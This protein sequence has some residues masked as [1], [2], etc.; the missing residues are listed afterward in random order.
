MTAGK[1]NRLYAAKTAKIISIFSFSISAL[2]LFA[3]LISDFSVRNLL[4]S[5]IPIAVGLLIW[6][7]FLLRIPFANALLKKQ[8]SSLNIKFDDSN[9]KPLYPSAMIFLS[10]EWFIAAG[11]LYL[12]KD[13]IHYVTVKSGKTAMGIEYYCVFKCDDGKRKLHMDSKANANK[14]KLWF[15][16]IGKLSKHELAKYAAPILKAKG[17]LKK[18]MRWTKTIGDF[19]VAF[20]IQSSNYNKDDYYIR[21]GVFMNNCPRAAR[22]FYGHFHTQID[23]T[24]PQMIMDET[25][26]FFREWTDKKLIVERTKAFII[27]DKRNPLEKRRAGLVDYEKDPVPSKVLFGLGEEEINYILSEFQS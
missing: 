15:E 24:E 5:A 3:A 19:T 2:F 20:Y 22:G 23:I 25:E 18:G 14:V 9:A 26:K 16:E 12:H 10:D 4:A 1:Y 17:F 6:F 11:K 27:W 7:A 21:P 8:T 13:F